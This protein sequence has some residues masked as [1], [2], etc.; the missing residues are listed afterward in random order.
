MEWNRLVLAVTVRRRAE[1]L[2]AL[3][4]AGPAALIRQMHY[5]D[6]Y[7]CTFIGIQSSKLRSKQ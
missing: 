7:D 2:L 4:L 5:W 6:D 1:G 3:A